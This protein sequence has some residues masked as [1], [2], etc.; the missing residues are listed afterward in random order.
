MPVLDGLELVRA[1]RA[2]PRNAILPIIMFTSKASRSD[3]VDALDA[4]VDGYVAKPFAP[5]QLREQI[6]TVLERQPRRRIDRVVKGLDP[7]RGEDDYPLLLIGEQAPRPRDLAR[8][9]NR[10]TLQFLDQTIAAIAR[11]N[12]DSILHLVGLVVADDTT[13]L[14]RRLRSLGSRAKAMIINVKMPCVLTLARLAAVNKKTDVGLF[15]TCDK[16]GEITEKIRQGLDRMD[17]TLL[18][19]DHLGVDWLQ[20]L[21]MEHAVAVRGAPRP[22]ELPSP[23]EINKRLRTDIMSAITLPVMPNVFHDIA[24]LSRDPESDLQKWIDVIQVD[25]LRSAQVVRRARSPVYG[26][27]GEIEQTDKAV[28]LLRK[29]AVKEL[30]VSEAVQRAFQEIQEDHFDLDDFWLHSVSVAVTARLL[31]LPLEQS[32]RTSEQQQDFEL[33][34]LSEQALATL[35]RLDLV[36]KLSL[37]AT[38]GP[39]TAGM[40]H[41][42]GKVALVHSYPGLNAA[43]RTELERN[44]WNVPMRQAEVMIAGGAD[45]TAV[46]AILAESWI[47]GERVTSVISN[48]HD[49][50]SR[51]P[52]ASMVALDDVVVGGIQPYPKDA[53]YPMVRLVNEK[54]ETVTDEV[55][56]SLSAFI[57]EGLCRHLGLSAFDLIELARGVGTL[58]AQ[59]GRR[60][61][62]KPVTFLGASGRSPAQPFVGQVEFCLQHRLVDATH[63]PAE[64]EVDVAEHCLGANGTLGDSCLDL[65]FDP[66]SSNSAPRSCRATRLPPQRSVH[67]PVSVPRLTGSVSDEPSCPP[68]SCQRAPIRVSTA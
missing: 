22:T 6:T 59:A 29:N 13:E 43:V 1:V 23:E 47:L 58:C 39:F 51:D 5:G 2:Q 30:V 42:I 41:D 38:I 54:D 52:L 61:A 20:Q 65:A 9:E 49:P 34:A 17:V 67:P 55:M 36:S 12:G 44:D 57:P 21:V 66:V 56:A 25:P 8:A 64:I 60:V 24:E 53:S 37:G 28:I 46:G 11:V 14:S 35:G 48:H 33:F 15:V 19:H 62:E 27:R 3:V 50:D 45:H 31:S 26:F 4:G 32:E 10:G 16:K 68:A 63:F 7:M 18:E 40:M